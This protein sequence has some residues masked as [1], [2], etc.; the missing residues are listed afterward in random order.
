METVNQ[1][2]GDKGLNVG[3]VTDT[4]FVLKFGDIENPMSD[5]PQMSVYK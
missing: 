3:G 1:Y 4:K 5:R 2:L